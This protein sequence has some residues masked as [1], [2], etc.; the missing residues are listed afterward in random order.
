MANH[1]GGSKSGLVTQRVERI[2][3]LMAAGQGAAAAAQLQ[4]LANQ[5]MGLSPRWIS[6]TDADALVTEADALRSA[7]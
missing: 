6:A 4:A 5:V 7:L 3:Q 1:L 2:D